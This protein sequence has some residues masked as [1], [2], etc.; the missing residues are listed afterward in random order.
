[1]EL[2]SRHN[3]VATAVLGEGE[4]FVLFDARFGDDTVSWDLPG[5]EPTAF[6]E[7][8]QLAYRSNEDTEGLLT[9]FA[10]VETT[11]RRSA[12]DDLMRAVAVC[13]TRAFFA[14]LRL[15]TAYAPYDGG[16]DV[17]VSSPEAVGPSRSAW[18]RWLSFREDGL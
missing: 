11:W 15:G 10:A 18:R 6:A 2:L 14:N 1:R 16:A 7:V 12:F 4:R 5:I 3:A 17:F 8:P 13:R 9:R